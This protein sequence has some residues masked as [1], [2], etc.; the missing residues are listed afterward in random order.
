MIKE[1]QTNFADLY[2]NESPPRNMPDTK[3]QEL[4]KNR[5]R[6]KAEN[7]VLI[8]SR[9]KALDLDRLAATFPETVTKIKRWFLEA[10]E[11]DMGLILRALHIQ[12]AASW[13]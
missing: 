1:P 4:S 5:R 10:S 12:V 11:D 9:S 8:A 6:L 2:V 13:E 7:R 3:S